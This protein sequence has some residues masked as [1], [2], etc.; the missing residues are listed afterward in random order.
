[1]PP[2]PGGPPERPLPPAGGRGPPGGPG[3]RGPRPTFEDKVATDLQ[4]CRAR[5]DKLHERHAKREELLGAL[6]WPGL[7]GGCVA[8]RPAE[9]LGCRWAWPACAAACLVR[10]D[11]GW[12]SSLPR[13]SKYVRSTPQYCPTAPQPTPC[14]LL[15]PPCRPATGG[16]GGT[17]VAVCQ[18]A[19]SGACGAAAT[20]AAAGGGRAWLSAGGNHGSSTADALCAPL[21]L[22]RA[23]C[24]APCP[25]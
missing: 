22:P 12:P 8:L 16:C 24:L 19:W 7:Q 15:S 9:H 17:G 10:L 3:G 25:H 23:S 14:R 11:F 13:A 1:M 4:S 20:A 5:L 6:L 21:R 18:R 2:R